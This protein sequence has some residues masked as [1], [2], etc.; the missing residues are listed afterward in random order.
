MS[1]LERRSRL[2]LRAYPAAYREARGEEIIGTLLEVTPEGRSWPLPRDICGLVTG[3]LRARATVNRRAHDVANLRE[4]ALVGV[5][6]SLAFILVG[7]V[8]FVV[9]AE[10]AL[11]GSTEFSAIQLAGAS[12]VAVDGGEC[13]AGID[14]PTADHRP[15]DCSASRRPAVLRRSLAGLPIHAADRRGGFPSRADRAGRWPGATGPTVALAGGLHGGIAAARRYPPWVLGI[16]AHRWVAGHR[17]GQ[18][19][20]APDRRQA[21]HRAGGAPAGAIAARLKSTTSRVA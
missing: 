9:A 6:S 1:T 13:R 4:A 8:N 14:E 7:Y 10:V 12:L 11:G 20:V 3:G 5:A 16:R 18:P 21:G 17:C 15:C 2:L 19:R